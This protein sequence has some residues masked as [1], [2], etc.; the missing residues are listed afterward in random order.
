MADEATKAWAALD[1][2]ATAVAEFTLRQYRTRLSTWV[3]VGCVAVALGTILLFYLQ[4]MSEEVVAVDN[5]GDASDPDGDGYPTGQEV[6]LGTD[7]YL[8]S[9]I[10]AISILLWLLT[11]RSDGLTKTA[12]RFPTPSSSTEA[13]PS[14]W[15]TTATAA[16]RTSRSAARTATATARRVTSSSARRIPGPPTC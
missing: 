7:P 8:R 1:R 12:L 5:D 4:A 2:K 15:T 6:S 13:P 16:E 10:R 3:V 14:A 11:R 9:T